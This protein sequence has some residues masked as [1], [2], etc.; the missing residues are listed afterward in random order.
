M[1]GAPCSAPAASQWCQWPWRRWALPQRR[2][3]PVPGPR[4]PAG[5]GAAAG[6]P[7]PARGLP[8]PDR[9]PAAAP[10]GL[11]DGSLRRWHAAGSRCP[12]CPGARPA[13]AA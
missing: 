13:S 7:V 4:Q 8:A 10:A 6:R 9:R 11:R 12:A 3:V 1:R 5:P 2:P